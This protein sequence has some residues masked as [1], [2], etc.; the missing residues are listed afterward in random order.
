METKR[1]AINDL[2]GYNGNHGDNMVQNLRVITAA[3]EER[4]G[5]SPTEALRYAS[6]ELETRGRGS[7]SQYYVSGLNQ[8]AERFEGRS[9]LSRGDVLTLVQSLLSAVPSEGH[10]QQMETGSSVFD[11]VLGLAGSQLPQGGEGT[12][13]SP[14]EGFL[15][16]Q[17][18]QGGEGTPGA[19]LGTLFGTPP[20]QAGG[21]EPG[22]PLEGFLSAQGTPGGQSSLGAAIGAILDA[23]PPQGDVDAPDAPV[24]GFLGAEQSQDSQ[25]ALGGMLGALLGGQSLQG[26]ENAPDLPLGAL[27]GSTPQQGGENPLSGMLGALLGGQ[28]SQPGQQGE[29]RPGNLIQALLPAAMAFLQAKQSGA[30]M[31]AAM[32]QALMTLLANRR[33][34]PLQVGT[35]RSAAGG[36]VAQ[37]MLQALGE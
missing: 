31:P 11:Q 2:D 1:Q 8:A 6:D 26:D 10:P 4:E 37:S 19:G 9:E 25:D 23:E 27:L 18:V 3:L 13:G 35:P 16:A 20:P 33:M 24:A 28:Q 14:L 7:T 36:L 34:D 22:S 5:A 32:G 17:G 29:N 21:D 12:P 30:E 15:G